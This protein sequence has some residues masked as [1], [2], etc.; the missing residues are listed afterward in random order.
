[1]SESTEQFDSSKPLADPAWSPT[2][3]SALEITSD[4]AAV[5][6]TP[7]TFIQHSMSMETDISS[8]TSKSLGRLE[9]N[10]RQRSYWR[11]DEVDDEQDNSI[12]PRDHVGAEE[13]H[14]LRTR[15]RFSA[16]SPT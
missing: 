13:V 1:V 6:P 4:K 14:I 15:Y 3:R 9:N 12:A 2:A 7:T 8:E 10:D 16:V 11:Y 5:I